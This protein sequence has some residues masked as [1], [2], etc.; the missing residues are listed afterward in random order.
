MIEFTIPGFVALLGNIVAGMDGA[1]HHALE[2]A[3][4][5]VEKEAKR[6]LGSYD[7]GWPPLKEETIARKATGDS[8]LLE[9]GEMR[10]SRFAVATAS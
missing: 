10:G 4:Q 8:P 2:K 7:Y 5:I 3:A 6:V 1:N 9:T